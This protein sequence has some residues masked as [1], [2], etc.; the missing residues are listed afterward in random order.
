MAVDTGKRRILRTKSQM[1]II[2]KSIVP[3]AKDYDILNT[4]LFHNPFECILTRPVP[5]RCTITIVFM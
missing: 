2:T 5:F 1:K 3:S 4:Y